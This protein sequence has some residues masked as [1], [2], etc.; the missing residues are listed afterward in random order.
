LREHSGNLLFGQDNVLYGILLALEILRFVVRVGREEE[1][2]FMRA[3]EMIEV[4][5]SYI[6]H[7]A[8]GIVIT[9]VPIEALAS[10]N[11]AYLLV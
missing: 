4:F 6:R 8:G 9:L 10:L 3:L 7:V 2:C 11:A 5:R 1:L